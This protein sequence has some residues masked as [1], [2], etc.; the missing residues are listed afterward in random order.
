MLNKI[1]IVFKENY[2]RNDQVYKRIPQFT[3]CL[4]IRMFNFDYW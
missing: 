1:H 4:N 3:V 2:V